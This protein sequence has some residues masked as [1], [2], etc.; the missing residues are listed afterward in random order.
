MAYAQKIFGQKSSGMV[1]SLYT[2]TQKGHRYTESLGFQTLNQS[3]F[4]TV[5]SL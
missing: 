4:A 1:L 5:N 3:F 2:L